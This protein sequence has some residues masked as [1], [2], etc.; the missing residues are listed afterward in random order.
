MAEL[1]LAGCIPFE[2]HA[3]LSQK[4]TVDA[5]GKVQAFDTVEGKRIEK[6]GKNQVKSGGP[7]KPISNQ[8]KRSPEVG[9][10]VLR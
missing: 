4:K 8:Y 6:I 9:M 5:S 2:G 10:L 3:Y 1:L 7:L